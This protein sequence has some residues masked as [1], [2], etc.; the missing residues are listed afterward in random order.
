MPAFLRRLDGF[1]V[2]I[3]AAVGF[4]LWAP[5]P[6]AHGGPLH[7]DAL[8]S[9][10]VT[11]VFFLHGAMLPVESLHRGV[12]NVR[13]HVVA[14]GTTYVVFP[15]LGCALLQLGDAGVPKPVAMGF[16]YLSTVS[17]TISSA[18]ALTALAG[19]DVAGSLF[20]ATL[21]GLLGVFLTPIYASL[22]AHSAG[23]TLSLGAVIESV[24][25]KILLPLVVGQ[26][27]RPLLS[28]VLDRHRQAAQLIDRGSIVLIVYGAFCDSAQ[29]GVWNHD[30]LVPALLS[31][32]LAAV[33][34]TAISGAVLAAIR[35]ARLDRASA[36][37]A[38]FCGSQKSLANGLPTAHAVFAGSSSLGLIV[39]P[40]LVYH[41]I[42]L[43]VGAFIARRLATGGFR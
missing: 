19:G 21:S 6:G 29:A 37:A 34:L 24:A 25:V 20:N 35:V 11:L 17:S 7:V 27:L 12:R 26:L 10:A 42:Q 15:L 8:T 5:G 4:A 43:A 31:V 1:S 30:S 23:M 9:V 22:L 16:F 18:V 40:L 38:Y 3:L 13:L 36:I 28:S 2:A 39:M 33:M 32:G 41:Q 14:Q